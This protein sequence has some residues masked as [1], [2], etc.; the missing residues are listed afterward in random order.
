MNRALRTQLGKD[1]DWA[2][3]SVIIARREYTSTFMQEPDTKVIEHHVFEKTAPDTWMNEEDAHT[4]P[5]MLSRRFVWDSPPGLR[6]STM[7]VEVMIVT[8]VDVLDA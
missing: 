8:A 6:K 1:G 2:I 4:F 7:T 3:G 5:G